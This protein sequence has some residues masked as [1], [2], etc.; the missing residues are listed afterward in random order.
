MLMF[1]MVGFFILFGVFLVVV[2]IR[3]AK[4]KANLRKTGKVVM[5]PIIDLSHETKRMSNPDGAAYYEDFFY[6]SYHFDGK[7]R[8]QAISKY[9]YENLNIGDLAPITHV[10]GHSRYNVQGFSINTQA[11]TPAER[12]V[13]PSS[14]PEHK[15]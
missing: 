9:D 2:I 5:L 10:N 12:F 14:R 6:L 1:L 7:D 8:R 15:A 3:E 13:H 4:I 11:Q